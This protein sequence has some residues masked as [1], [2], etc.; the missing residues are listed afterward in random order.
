MLNRAH[1]LDRLVLAVVALGLV[2]STVSANVE[3]PTSVSKSLQTLHPQ[4]KVLTANV[5]E[6]GLYNIG[7]SVKQEHFLVEVTPSGRV[8]SNKSQGKVQG[9]TQNAVKLPASAVAAVK[10]LY[11]QGKVASVTTDEDGIF[12]IRID[13]P[14][15]VS[16]VEATRSGRILRHDRDAS[17]QDEDLTVSTTSAARHITSVRKLPAPVLAAVENSHPRGVIV[18]VHQDLYGPKYGRSAYYVNIVK[19]DEVHN[20][21]LT[22]SGEILKNSLDNQTQRL[23]RLP[24]VVKAA[25]Q[26]AFPNGIIYGAGTRNGIHQVDVLVDG[27]PYDLEISKTGQLISNKRDYHE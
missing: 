7:L 17:D 12:H 10:K 11:P 25:A 24:Q 9:L 20:V 21:G 14:R 8:I 3:L 18:H 5:D 13:T 6:D 23:A 27:L 15:G 1:Q 22:E 19:G 26:R 2:T 4:A 16:T